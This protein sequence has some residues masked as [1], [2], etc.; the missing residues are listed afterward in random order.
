MSNNE[1]TVHFSYNSEAQEI[2]TCKSNERI[3]SVCRE[4]TS[5]KNLNFDSVYF[6]LGGKRLDNTQYEKPV[7]DYLSELNEGHLIILLYDELDL[8]DEIVENK[9]LDICFWFRGFMTK[10]ECDMTSNVID[11][12]KLF[13]SLLDRDFNKLSFKYRNS[14]LDLDKNFEEIATQTDKNKGVIE[15]LVEEKIPGQNID[16]L[17]SFWLNKKPTNIKCFLSSKMRDIF[18]RYAIKVDKVYEDLIFINK[19]QKLDPKKSFGEIASIEE[20]N[21]GAIDIFVEDINDIQ[22]NEVA[23]NELR[24]Q[25]LLRIQPIQKRQTLEPIQSIQRNQSIEFDQIVSRSHSFHPNPSIYTRP[26]FIPSQIIQTSDAL[27]NMQQAPNENP[28]NIEHVPDNTSAETNN[29]SCLRKCSTK[30]LIIGIIVALII[31]AII[32]VI[33]F[34]III[35]RY[36][37]KQDDTDRCEEYEDYSKKKKKKCK[38][39]F[40]L[41]KG[42]CLLSTIYAEYYINYPNER[43]QLFNPDKIEYIIAILI[44][45]KM[46]EPNPEYSFTGD[47]VSVIFYMYEKTSISLSDM[48]KNNKNLKNF[49]FSSKLIENFYI[50]DIKG[51]FSGCTNLE[52]AFFDT[53]IAKNITDISG[54]FSNCTYLQYTDIENFDLSQVKYMNYSFYNCQ[55][56]ARFPFFNGILA[57]N[58]INMSSMFSNCISLTSIQFTGTINTKESVDMSYIFFNCERLKTLELNGFNNFNVNNMISMFANCN[59]LRSLNLGYFNTKNVIDMSYMFKG[60]NSLT[61]IVFGNLNTENVKTMDGMFY[62][63]NSLTSLDLSNFNTQNIISMKEIFYGCSSLKYIDIS[64]FIIEKDISIFSELPEDCTVKINIKSNNKINV[65]PDSCDIIL[66]DN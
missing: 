29:T 4:I 58:V 55:S 34:V 63:C 52:G 53:Y 24:A 17:V 42:N 8:D 11:I 50:T 64:S 3:E 48:F 59:S 46:Y 20:L 26:P 15:I 36:S 62:N 54:L 37:E 28:H 16:I 5:R 27:L 30:K 2:F 65:I 31:I 49:L 60:C 40:T 51:M 9:K 10:V 1:I 14:Q 57:N 13:A 45:D 38:K 7:S 56:I 18:R 19:N 21:N 23:Q 12:S 44:N 39:D 25:S 47:S 22:I 43:I 35:L 32:I 6:L 41:Y 33:V 66:N 61:S